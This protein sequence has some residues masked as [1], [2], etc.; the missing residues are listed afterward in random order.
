MRG[1][2]VRDPVAHR[3]VDGVLQRGTC[4]DVTLRTSAPRARIR[5]TFGRLAGDVLRAHVDDAR[6]AEQRAR[7]R[8]R[9]AVLAGA[10]LG[11]DPGL[12]EPPGEQ[13]LAQRVVDLVGAGVGEVLALEVA[14]AGAGSRRAPSA[15]LGRRRRLALHGLGE[16]IRAVERRRP[17]R[18]IGA[19][20]S[21]SSD[22]NTGSWRSAS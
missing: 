13:R 4:P 9:D 18:R 10:G 2:D 17:A 22:Q 15:A 16:A 19:S 14:G 11:D 20:S 12:A 5:S 3:L 1:L 7:G 6:Q 21:R 8:G